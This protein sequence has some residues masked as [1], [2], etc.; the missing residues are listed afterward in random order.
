MTTLAR[1]MDNY[2]TFWRITAVCNAGVVEEEDGLVMLTTRLPIP[3]FNPAALLAWPDDPLAMVARVRDFA[4]RHGCPSVIATWGEVAT[5]FTPIARH[6]GLVDDGATPVMLLTPDEQRQPPPV[7]GLA[8][9][10]VTPELRRDYAETAVIGNGMPL[11][12]AA[13]FACD[14][15]FEHPGVTAYLGYMDDRPVAT[16]LLLETDG[17]AGVHVVATLP[18]YRRRG[19]GAALTARCA[20]DGFDH[21]CEVSALQSSSLGFPVYERL[22]YRQVTAIQGWTFA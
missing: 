3:F 4:T 16:A 15:L 11:A 13:V 1:A 14:A 2:L 18:E 8:I 22:G 6:L 7:D 10:V 9:A 21:G 12:W 19:I 17:V 5:R 20:T